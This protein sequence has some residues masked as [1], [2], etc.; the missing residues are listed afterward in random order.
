MA[1]SLL[2]RAGLLPFLVVRVSLFFAIDFAAALLIAWLLASFLEYAL[3][4]SQAEKRSTMLLDF[5]GLPA[6]Y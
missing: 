6:Y 2:R 1:I 5:S 3:Y 4:C